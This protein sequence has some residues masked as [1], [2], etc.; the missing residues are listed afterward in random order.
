[1]GPEKSGAGFPF[2]VRHPVGSTGC[3]VSPMNYSQKLKDPRWQKKR[4]EVMEFNLF[5]CRTCGSK[6]ETLTVH[7]INY[8]RGAE[9]WEYC[10]VND[11]A[12]ICEP[13]HTKIE[14]EVIP[15]L[16]E[17]AAAIHPDAMLKIVAALSFGKPSH[18]MGESPEL[19][20]ADYAECSLKNGLK[21]FRAE[22]IADLVTGLDLSGAKRNPGEFFDL[23]SAI[24]ERLT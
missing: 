16:R 13:C 20:P 15:Q 12:C 18:F 23:V 10:A 4:L 8:R 3:F 14:K 21:Y 2:P 6:T 17:L 24:E 1:M 11:L 5:T 19:N 7:H 22:R 9:P